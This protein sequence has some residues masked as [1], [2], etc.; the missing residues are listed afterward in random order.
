MFVNDASKRLR[1]DM[2]R[3]LLVLHLKQ[4]D[5]AKSYG[6]IM[7]KYFDKQQLFD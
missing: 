2:C 1:K 3:R 6:L 4:R 5:A 7:E